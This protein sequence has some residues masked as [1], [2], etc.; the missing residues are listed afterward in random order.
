[1]KQFA[2]KREWNGE[3]RESS[4]EN[5]KGFFFFIFIPDSVEGNT[6]VD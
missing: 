2:I 5:V 1:M 3:L 4:R 6:R